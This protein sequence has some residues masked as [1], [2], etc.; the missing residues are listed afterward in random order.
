MIGVDRLETQAYTYIV[1]FFCPLHVFQPVHLM[2]K[3][4]SWVAALTL[5]AFIQSQSVGLSANPVLLP[6]PVQVPVATSVAHHPYTLYLGEDPYS[7]AMLR[8]QYNTEEKVLEWQLL[9][10]GHVLTSQLHPMPENTLT[11]DNGLI[12]DGD[13]IIVTGR[14]TGE[15]WFIY[16]LNTQGEFQWRRQGRGHIED[17]AFSHDGDSVYA[18]GNSR[19]HPLLLEVTARSGEIGFHSGADNRVYPD[20]SGTLYKQIVVTGDKELVIAQHREMDGQLRLIKWRA[21]VDAVSGETKW[22][23]ES[24]FCKECVEFGVQSIAIKQIWIQNVFVVIYSNKRG[25][26]SELRDIRSG[27]SLETKVELLS[28]VVFVWNKVLRIEGTSPSFSYKDPLAQLDPTLILLD[29]GCKIKISGAFLTDEMTLNFCAHTEENHHARKLLQATPEETG[30][31]Q[32]DSQGIP[33]SEQRAFM[34]LEWLL[35]IVG[36]I[37]ITLVVSGIFGIGWGIKRY[38]DKQEGERKERVSNA[39]NQELHRRSEEGKS[40]FDLFK[41]STKRGL[42]GFSSSSSAS[43]GVGDLGIVNFKGSA[44]KSDADEGFSITL[45]PHLSTVAIDEDDDSNYVMSKFLDKRKHMH[46]LFDKARKGMFKTTDDIIGVE[47]ELKRDRLYINASDEAGN[48]FLHLAAAYKSSDDIDG[49]NLKSFI[50]FLISNGAHVDTCNLSGITP[51]VLSAL[52]GNIWVFQEIIKSRRIDMRTRSLLFHMLAQA[53]VYNPKPYFKA[54]LD[55]D[56][57]DGFNFMGL[58]NEEWLTCSKFSS[59]SE[60]GL[61]ILHEAAI[62]GNHEIIELILDKRMV[63][64]DEVDDLGNTA[65]HYA[66]LH[67][68]S[69]FYETIAVLTKRGADTTKENKSGRSPS[70]YAESRNINLEERKRVA[71]RFSPDPLELQH[72]SSRQNLERRS[73][74]TD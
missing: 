10:N 23:V 25:L 19:N 73:S 44:T 35:G 2:L 55:N 26:I 52:V 16:A 20:D 63:D 68:N 67:D 53:R 61:T 56:Q 31:G 54:M 47:D 45:T 32:S 49:K 30:S 1:F 21:A 71:M 38:L 8:L 12:Y 48:T 11:V 64:I 4:S 58:Q 5:V 6:E 66:A 34:N 65:L 57:H 14:T 74:S 41:H 37:E 28:S 22:G 9:N 46:S 43:F 40:L 18:I 69:V 59:V 50:R 60:G 51:I 13:Q 36:I 27:R 7:Q 72:A 3:P 33:F 24:G 39:R 29:N 42:L 62:S 70:N 15:R 17:L